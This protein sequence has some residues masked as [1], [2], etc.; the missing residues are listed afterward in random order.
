MSVY[1]SLGVGPGVMWDVADR[2]HACMH[3]TFARP[4]NSHACLDLE[5][6]TS[7][8]S[9]MLVRQE[10]APLGWEGVFQMRGGGA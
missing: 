9:N 1:E 3:V 6:V 8:I 2:I 5:T 4:F 10:G 7:H